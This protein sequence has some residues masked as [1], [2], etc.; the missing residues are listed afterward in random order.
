SQAID[1]VLLGGLLRRDAPD[2]I[3]ALT[4]SNLE[5]LHADIAFIGADGIDL[6]GNIYNAS[7]AVGRM[8][9]KMAGSANQVYVVADSSKIGR[10]AL[11]RFG[12]IVGWDGLITDDGIAPEH[13]AAL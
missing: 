13:L 9:G 1:L 3:G 6:Q 7:L 12:N 4:E 8:L 5:T 11:T 10:P 2:L